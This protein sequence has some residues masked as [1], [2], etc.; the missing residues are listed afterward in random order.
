MLAGLISTPAEYFS[1]ADLSASFL[2]LV[3]PWIAYSLM[4]VKKMSVHYLFALGYSFFL[5][6]YIYNLTVYYV[7]TRIWDYSLTV[8]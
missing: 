8:W 7:Y 3:A 1:V 2:L 4:E 6:F 5:T